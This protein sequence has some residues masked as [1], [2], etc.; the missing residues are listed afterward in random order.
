MRSS[1]A[2]TINAVAPWTD[3]YRGS[4]ARWRPLGELIGSERK[5]P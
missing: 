4:A 1:E 5:A 3:E 2:T